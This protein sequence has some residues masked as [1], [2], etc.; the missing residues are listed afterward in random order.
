MRVRL[1]T[2]SLQEYG[3]DLMKSAY[4]CRVTVRSCYAHLAADT[5]KQGWDRVPL[6]AIAG[7]LAVRKIAI[8]WSLQMPVWNP[9]GN[10]ACFSA[11]SENIS[12][13]RKGTEKREQSP[14]LRIRFAVFWRSH[15]ESRQVQ[16]PLS[17]ASCNHL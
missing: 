10:R 7:I 16:A 3:S 15:G 11:A 1:G 4:T 6:P 17:V 8:M 9:T 2:K 12:E 14:D 13:I 5:T